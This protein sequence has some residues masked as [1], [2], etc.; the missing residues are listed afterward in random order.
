MDIHE[1]GHELTIIEGEAALRE[2][3][4]RQII[5][6]MIGAAIEKYV[7]KF[8]QDGREVTGLTIHGINDASNQR[9]GIDIVDVKVNE[10][11]THFQTLVRA[12]DTV[13]NIEKVGACA[14]A[15]TKYTKKGEKYTDEFAFVK[16]V[17]KAQRN[18]LKQLLPV[19]LIEEVIKH[20]LGENSPRRPEEPR[21]TSTSHRTNGRDPN[22]GFAF[23]ALRELR[24]QLTEAGIGDEQITAWMRFSLGVA[25]R[26]DAT[27]EQ[28]AQ[29]RVELESAVG[30]EDAFV[31]LV[32]DMLAS[33]SPDNKEM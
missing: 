28:W 30:D 17:Q 20:Y 31:R 4:D 8:R 13:R 16:S 18:A 12:R 5:E 11:P 25:S 15:K 29:L 26:A 22:Q 19:V 3:E 21:Q 10:T 2:Y 33:P 6:A 24:P 7:Y 1:T 9:G 14:E 23:A 27:P 32:S